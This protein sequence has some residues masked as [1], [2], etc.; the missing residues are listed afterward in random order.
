MTH[1]T[2]CTPIFLLRSC[3][4]PGWMRCALAL[5]PALPKRCAYARFTS[6]VPKLG[7]ASGP[8][9]AASSS[10]AGLQR[11]GRL[12]ERV[13]S[14]PVVTSGA[15]WK[16]LRSSAVSRIPH[17]IP[18]RIPRSQYDPPAFWPSTSHRK[19]ESC[20]SVRVSPRQQISKFYER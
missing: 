12:K 8:A 17:R 20:G 19:V 14:A 2:H 3:T 10:S 11:R 7:C 18:L 1:E 6:I 9:G 15:N 5:K 16:G 4:V 13:A